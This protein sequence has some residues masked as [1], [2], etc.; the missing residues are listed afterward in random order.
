MAGPE[1]GRAERAGTVGERSRADQHERDDAVLQQPHDVLSDQR[2]VSAGRKPKT[3]R[4]RVQPR[5]ST[6]VRVLKKKRAS[7]T[8][9]GF[10]LSTVQIEF[11]Q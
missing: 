5:R 8:P 11:F 2:E 10:F 3:H 6:T 9:P 7:L 4:H 1:E